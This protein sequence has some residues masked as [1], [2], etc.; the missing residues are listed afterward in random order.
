M[1]IYPRLVEQRVA[2]AM[3]DTR[4]VMI[5]GPR[6]SGKTTLAKKM[7]NAEMEYF[8]LDN[9]TTLDAAQQD[10]VGFVRGMDR[11]IIDEVQRAPELLL[12]I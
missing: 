3:L 11:A 2:D 12:A 6:Q 10:P 1:T 8:T 4:V 9:A 5:V 7:A